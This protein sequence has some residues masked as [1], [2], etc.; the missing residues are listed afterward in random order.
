MKKTTLTITTLG[1]LALLLCGFV[2]YLSCKKDKLQ[3]PQTTI[4]TTTVPDYRL[5]FIGRYYFKRYDNGENM[6]G[7]YYS[8][9]SSYNSRITINPS[10]NNSIYIYSDTT[11]HFEVKI[12]T[13][14]VM[15]TISYGVS[16]T[17]NESG[18]HFIGTDSVYYYNYT[19]DN[20]YNLYSNTDVFGKKISK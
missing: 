3:A 14:G 8:D 7:H 13:H 6:P 10:T 2:F 18:G 20:R 5:K 19:T 16:A 15:P 11:N 4:P 12:D 1:L 9:S 17:L